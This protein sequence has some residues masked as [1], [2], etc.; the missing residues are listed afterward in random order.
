MFQT[1]IN[2]RIVLIFF[3]R[4]NLAFFKKL[5]SLPFSLDKNDKIWYFRINFARWI[6]LRVE[7][8]PLFATLKGNDL[9]LVE[10]LTDFHNKLIGKNISNIAS[11]QYSWIW[12]LD[13]CRF[14]MVN[15]CSVFKWSGFWMVH[16]PRMF[17]SKQK[18]Y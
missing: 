11:V 2:F 6:G 7:Q 4:V 8:L 10:E 12:N 3:F 16:K 9:V 18:F 17:L 13:I 5:H 15:L 1:F 14:R